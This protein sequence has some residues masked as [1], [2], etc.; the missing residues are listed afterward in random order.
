MERSHTDVP[1]WGP[2]SRARWI[3]G[4]LVALAVGLMGLVEVLAQPSYELALAVGLLCPAVA[5]VVNARELLAR[6]LGPFSA[7]CHCV[8]TAVGL[9]LIAYTV[10][11]ARGLFSGFCDLQSATLLFV[12]GPGIGTILGGLWGGIAAELARY[13]SSRPG[14]QMGLAV[15]LALAGPLGSATLQLALFYLT[16]MVFA[17]DP[18]VGFFSGALYDTIVDTGP[19]LSYRAASAATLYACYV[20]TLHLERDKNSGKLRYAS[21]GRPGLLASGVI[22]SILSLLCVLGGSRLGHWQTAGSIQAALGGAHQQGR[23]RVLHD[24]AIASRDVIRLARDCDA[25]VR[26]IERWLDQQTKRVVTVYLF[27]NAQQKRRLMGA[28]RTSIAKPWRGEIYLHPSGYPHPVLRHELVHALAASLARGPF[29]VAGKWGGWLPNPGL[30]EGLAVAA[31]PQDD[32]L[33][34]EQWAATMK[35]VGLLPVV[36]DLF[37]LKFLAGHSRTS[38][39][40]AGA[41]LRYVRDRYGAATVARWYGGEELPTMAALSW[42]ELERN[43]HQT[44]DKVKLSEAAL[45]E[46]RARFDRPGVFARRCPHVVDRTLSE[47][48]EQLAE[49]DLDGALASY[50]RVLALDPHNVGASLRMARCRDRRGELQLATTTLTELSTSPAVAKATQLL[51]L[52]RLGDLALRAAQPRRARALYER[53]RQSVVSEHRLRT[54]DIK[55][56]YAAS[57]GGRNALLALLVGRS[58][59]GPN[60]SEALDLFGQWRNEAP[61]DAT[62]DYL[63]ARQ[64][65]ASGNYPLAANRLDLAL[66]KTQPLQRVLNE[67][68]RLRIEVACALGQHEAARATLSRYALRPQVAKPRL[69]HARALVARCTETPSP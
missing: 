15:V 54:I 44:L 6:R 10:A 48:G 16:P 14:R 66:G 61:T 25:H 50:Q 31:A 21:L 17:F 5:A 20:A 34:A 53:A 41:F 2:M 37:A 43:W 29:G 64:H 42:T 32:N 58:H 3:G 12:L 69:D 65:I 4:G 26:S 67:T 11:L 38:Y 1:R 8:G 35:Q 19:L 56:H 39:T 68:L 51:A 59:R 36:S 18:F 46:G 57:L 40:A 7:F 62:P 63:F 49:G 60:H 45:A 9:C 27:R 24:R 52:E 30:I 13:L 22:A 47:A 55:H 33:S 28:A 23:C